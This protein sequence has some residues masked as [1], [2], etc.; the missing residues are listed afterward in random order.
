MVAGGDS[1]CKFS[2]LGRWYWQDHPVPS[3]PT[4]KAQNAFPGSGFNKASWEEAGRRMR[5]KDPKR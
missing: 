4:L 1:L 2:S 5:K 3:V